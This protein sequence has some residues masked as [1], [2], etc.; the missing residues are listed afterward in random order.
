VVKPAD[1]KSI[2]VFADLTSRERR[3]VARS[4]HEVRFA[5]GDDIVEEGRFAHAFFVIE[6]GTADVYE[7]GELV[8]QLG[9]GDIV[10]EIGVL[11]TDKRTAS[12]IATSGVQA[13]VING[14]ELLVLAHRIP[15]LY[16]QLQESVR[17]RLSDGDS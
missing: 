10:G 9:P 15:R 12:V 14:P 17:D 16:Q 6:S 5:E 8:R 3:L 11:Q 4:A 13:L 2:P 7:R 1:L